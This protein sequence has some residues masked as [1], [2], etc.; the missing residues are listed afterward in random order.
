MKNSHPKLNEIE[1]SIEKL[2]DASSLKS[3]YD[4]MATLVELG[5]IV[6]GLIRF[7]AISYPDDLKAHRGYTKR[8]AILVG[9]L[10]RLGK[11]YDCLLDNICKKRAEIVLILRRL[12][13]ETKTKMEYLMKSKSSS[14]RSFVISSLRAEKETLQDMKTKKKQR[15]LLPIEKRMMRSVKKAIKEAGISQKE[16]FTIRQWNL[17]GKDFRAILRDMGQEKDYLYLYRT[18]SHVIHGDWADLLRH[19]LRKKGRF[20]RPHLD[21]NIPDPRLLAPVSMMLLKFILRYIEKFKLDSGC[22]LTS[23]IDKLFNKFLEIDRA[24]ESFL[25]RKTP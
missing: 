23:L 2:P 15:P 7:I 11:L 1:I 25:P 10:I 21:Y 24:H 8:H 9:L 18:P 3:N 17:D 16:L 19:H 13:S 5:N 22:D 12:I 4:F 14:Y 6:L 20:Y